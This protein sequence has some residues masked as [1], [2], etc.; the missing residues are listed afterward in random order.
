MPG[1]PRIKKMNT[2][3]DGLYYLTRDCNDDATHA[4]GVLVGL[5]NGLVSMGMSYEEA[6]HVIVGH[7]N[8]D[9][10]LELFPDAWANDAY[11]AYRLKWS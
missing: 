3:R 10:R 4:R 2:F 11:R 9:L 8:Q 7:A 1:T 5:L 6:I